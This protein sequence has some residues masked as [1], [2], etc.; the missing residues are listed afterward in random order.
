MEVVGHKDAALSQRPLLAA[1][2][3]P[4]RLQ[5]CLAQQGTAIQDLLPAAAVD[6]VC[7]GT[8][9]VQDSDMAGWCVQ[10][11]ECAA[12]SA[13]QR[14]RVVRGCLHML[15]DATQQIGPARTSQWAWATQRR[16]AG[17]SGNAW[18]ARTPSRRKHQQRRC[19]R[20]T[21]TRPVAEGGVVQ[22][23]IVDAVQPRVP[24]AHIRLAATDLQPQAH[25]RVLGFRVAPAGST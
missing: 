19:M 7:C 13:A 15:G 17:W 3:Q 22:E 14:G 11:A 23:S 24:K 25:A 6:L 4:R 9:G 5:R 8:G 18:L 10:P 20:T 1:R 21:L 12:C 16:L 2:Q